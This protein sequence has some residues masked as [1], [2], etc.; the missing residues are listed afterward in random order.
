[1][2]VLSIFLQFSVSSKCIVDIQD[3]AVLR[4]V[5]KQTQTF[6]KIYVDDIENGEWSVIE[7]SNKLLGLPNT[8]TNKDCVIKI[9]E[10][11]KQLMIIKRLYG[12]A[13]HKDK[14]IS[15]LNHLTKHVISK[16]WTHSL[17]ELSLQQQ[18]DTINFLLTCIQ[19]ENMQQNIIIVYTL[20]SF[21]CSLTKSKQKVINNRDECIIAYSSLKRIVIKKCLELSSC[22]REEITSYPYVFVDRVIRKVGEVKRQMV[23]LQ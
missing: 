10:L 6:V 7:T 21:I 8:K 11:T 9:G 4:C 3:I 16:L 23:S 13:K 20:M 15:V 22:L 19:N 2:D 5:S 1:M 14:F 12:Q 18:K 17:S